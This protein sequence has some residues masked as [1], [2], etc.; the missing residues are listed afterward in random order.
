M[1]DVLPEGVIRKM[2]LGEADRYRD[3]LLRLDAES[4]QQPLRRRGV[5]RVS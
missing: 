1:H 2:W 3:H 5:G 4:R